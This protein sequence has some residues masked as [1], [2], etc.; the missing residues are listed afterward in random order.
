[1]AEGKDSKG[2][3]VHGI[4]KASAQ[5]HLVPGLP[6]SCPQQVTQASPSAV[7]GV[8]LLQ[9]ASVCGYRILLEGGK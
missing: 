1:M 8:S 4:F 2:H 7:A 3:S 6:V 5:A 9:E